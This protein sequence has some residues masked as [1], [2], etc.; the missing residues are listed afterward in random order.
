QSVAGVLAN[1]HGVRCVAFIDVVRIGVTNVRFALRSHP[2]LQEIAE[3]AVAVLPADQG[4]DAAA[5]NEMLARLDRRSKRGRR[6]MRG[7]RDCVP[8]APITSG[9][10]GVRAARQKTRR[11][12]WSQPRSAG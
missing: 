8:H 12:R 11:T 2:Q 9:G 4:L 3:G 10:A 7:G 6:R 1:E 5:M